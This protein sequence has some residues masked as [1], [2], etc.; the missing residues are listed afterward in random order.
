MKG[1]YQSDDNIAA[2]TYRK[3]NVLVGRGSSYQIIFKERKGMRRSGGLI[4]V[5]V[6]ARAVVGGGCSS[7][8]LSPW[9]WEH[10]RGVALP[11]PLLPDL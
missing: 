2:K 1:K 11:K 3:Q 7:S 6:R 8:S 10:C 4:P 5:K 9:V